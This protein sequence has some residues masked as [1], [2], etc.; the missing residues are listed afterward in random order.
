MSSNLKD[1]FS[2]L[3]LISH[4]KNRRAKQVLL[5]EFAR[6]SKFCDAFR[7]IARNAVAKNIPLTQSEKRKLRRHKQTI[8]KLSR[9]SKGRR[10]T[11][12]VQQTGSGLFL[13]LVLPYVASV[14][15]SLVK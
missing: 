5:K 3:Q 13:P 10:H 11:K 8:V 6:D 1:Q 12:L 2:K 4:T 9:A 7:E 14:I 15:A